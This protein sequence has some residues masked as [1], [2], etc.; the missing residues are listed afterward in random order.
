MSKILQR[1]PLYAAQKEV[2]WFGNKDL[3]V[4]L[5]YFFQVWIVIFVL[6]TNAYLQ[7]HEKKY[8]HSATQGVL[9]YRGI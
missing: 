8:T 5:V 9:E 4:S 1:I 6:H 3:I 7:V 2:Q